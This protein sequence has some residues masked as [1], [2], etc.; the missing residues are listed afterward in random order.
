MGGGVNLNEYQIDGQYALA[1]LLLPGQNVQLVGFGNAGAALGTA[2]ALA[3]AAAQAQATPA[4]RAR[5]A[6][7]MAYLNVT[8]WDPSATTPAPGSDPAGQEAAQYNVLFSGAFS[9][10]DFIELGRVS[11]DQA[12]G[13]QATWDVGTNFAGA[14]RHSPFRHEVGALYK[15][16]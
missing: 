12:D 6:L 10:M 3:A 15:A 1:Q 7:A 9:I 11:I 13:G 5:L 8:P 2:A 14:L 4:G 16:R